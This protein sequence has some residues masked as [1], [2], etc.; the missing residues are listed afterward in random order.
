MEV[1]L[2]RGFYAIVWWSLC[3]EETNSIEIFL[4]NVFIIS[5]IKKGTCLVILPPSGSLHKWEKGN[6]CLDPTP[7]TVLI[8]HARIP[9]STQY[10]HFLLKQYLSEACMALPPLPGNG[11]CMFV[12]ASVSLMSPWFKMMQLRKTFYFHLN[13]VL[14][15]GP[16]VS[17]LP[18]VLPTS[19]SFLPFFPIR[20]MWPLSCIIY[21]AHS[22][23]LGAPL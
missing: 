10:E 2:W 17:P 19:V 6:K 13:A 21:L 8:I 14:R 20:R 7:I 18:S 9:K 22:P 15:N 16:F 3:E 4:Y 11:L 5:S 1:L 23:A 12:H